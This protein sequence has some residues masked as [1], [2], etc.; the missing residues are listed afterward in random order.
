MACYVW[1]LSLDVVKIA[2]NPLFRSFIT[3]LAGKSE[4]V[5]S[6]LSPRDRDQESQ[7]PSLG[8]PC[9][10]YLGFR[11]AWWLGSKSEPP[12]RARQKLSTFYESHIMSLLPKSRRGTLMGSSSPGFKAGEHGPRISM[13]RECQSHLIR[14]ACAMGVTVVY[15]KRPSFPREVM[16]ELRA[17]G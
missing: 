17:K 11:M 15:I 16:L 8:G 6:W 13:R 5:I 2:E 12:K 10:G 9:H 14:I 3:C 7:F 4:L 1:L